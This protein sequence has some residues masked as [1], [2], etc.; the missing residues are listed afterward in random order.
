MD[1]NFEDKKIK[2]SGFGLQKM[3][4]RINVLNGNLN[5]DSSSL[6]GTTIKITIPVEIK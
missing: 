2:S 1:Y 6:K 4:E 3:K 5:I